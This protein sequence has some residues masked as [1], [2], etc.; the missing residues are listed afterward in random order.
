MR[1]LI[2][3]SSGF[4][5]T[6]LTE[7]L[8]VLGHDVTRLVRRPPGAGEVRWDPYTA[9]LGH[10][11]VDDH[12]VVVNLGGTPT[13]GNPHSKKWARDLKDSRVTTTRVLAEAI[14]ESRNK[15]VF[16]AGNAVGIYGDHGD[17]PV[18][19]ATHP[20]SDTLLAGVTRAWQA[21]AQPARHAGGRVCI[22]RTSPVYDRRSQPLG[23]LRLQFKAGLGGRLGDGR[24]YVPM[25]STRDW[26]D[27]VIH[28]A[29][30]D[31]ISGPVNL[32][33]QQVPTNAELTR[34]LARLVRRPAFMH[35]PARVI[36]LGAGPMAPEA[37]GSVNVRPQVLL[38]SGFTFSD[39]AVASVLREGLNPSR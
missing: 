16:L 14:A 3:G 8:A 29:G 25:I 31:S 7:R 11:V 18:T 24:Q 27:A 10:E 32:S 38:D 1:F 17:E 37:L 20:R 19:E 15:P 5:G 12:D 21:A 23:A 22:L 2:A 9:P 4:L 30:T 35:V 13:V 26:V 34:E 36:R 6:R 39:P 28:L 33:C